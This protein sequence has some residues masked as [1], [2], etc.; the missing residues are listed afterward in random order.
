[1]INGGRSPR[2]H[3]G[4]DI[5][6]PRHD[7]SNRIS[8]PARPTPARAAATASGSRYLTQ[9]EQSEQFVADEDK[10][11]LKQAKKKADIRVRENRAKP[12]DYLA[13]NLR[14]RRV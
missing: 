9:D 6:G 12:I 2:K 3:E 13:F 11:V 10:F 5:T 14:F 1:M 8:K 4:R 7:L